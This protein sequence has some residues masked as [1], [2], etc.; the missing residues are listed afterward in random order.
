[1]RKSNK[2]ENL[3]LFGLVREKALGEPEVFSGDANPILF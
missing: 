1:M 3:L 2:S